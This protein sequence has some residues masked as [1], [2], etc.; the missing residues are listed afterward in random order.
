[1]GRRSKSSRIPR[2]PRNFLKFLLPQEVPRNF[3]LGIPGISLFF[4]K[5][6]H[7]RRLGDTPF[8]QGSRTC[9]LVVE[10]ETELLPSGLSSFFSRFFRTAYSKPPTPARTSI[11]H[12]PF[13]SAT[14]SATLVPSGAK[15]P[16][17]PPQ[18]LE[19]YP[20]AKRNARRSCPRDAGHASPSNHGKKPAS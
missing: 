14:P 15:G 5:Q 17:G 18:H 11:R 3:F 13:L 16:P 8:H 9:V 20:N 4:G 6:L 1:M 2:V 7:Q 10:S 19:K 12:N